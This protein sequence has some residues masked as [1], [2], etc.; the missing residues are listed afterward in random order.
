MA[1]AEDLAKAREL[2]ARAAAFRAECSTVGNWLAGTTD[3]CAASAD[4]L[5]RL[6]A[7]LEAGGTPREHTTADKVLE[8]AD[9]REVAAG[10]S[11]ADLAKD[12][13]KD[14][15]VVGVGLGTALAVGAGVV[16]AVKFLGGRKRG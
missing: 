13:G 4:E 12:V 5:D 1:T 15:G 11:L 16:L 9:P 2:R 6:A 14:L 7:K 8:H 3:A 10:S